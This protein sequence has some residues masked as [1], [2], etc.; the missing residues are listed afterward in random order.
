MRAKATCTTTLTTSLAPGR[1]IPSSMRSS[2]SRA[3]STRSQGRTQRARAGQVLE[4]PRLALAAVARKHGGA[5]SSRRPTAF[6]P[7]AKRSKPSLSPQDERPIRDRPGPRLAR[8][9]LG[10]R[11]Q[12]HL[13]PRPRGLR[14]PRKRRRHPRGQ[15]SGADL[16]GERA[17]GRP[18][19]TLLFARPLLEVAGGQGGRGRYAHGP[20]ASQ[21]NSSAVASAPQTRKGSGGAGAPT[22]R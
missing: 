16:T 12:A 20:D 15:A 9:A 22:K 18:G 1:R 21:L 10:H 13:E 14:A 8:R 4:L 5:T 17:R 7:R 3:R 11:D 6:T 19:A 2:R